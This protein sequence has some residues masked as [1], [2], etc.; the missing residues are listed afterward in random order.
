MCINDLMVPLGPSSRS[1]SL[2][3]CPLHEQPYGEAVS[4]RKGEAQSEG[5]VGRLQTQIEAHRINKHTRSRSRIT[6][7]IYALPFARP[8]CF[9][10]T[11]SH[12][13]PRRSYERWVVDRTRWVGFSTGC[14]PCS[15]PPGCCVWYSC[16]ILIHFDHHSSIIFCC[17]LKVH[18]I[19]FA[20]LFAVIFTFSFF[21]ESTQECR[22]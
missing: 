16:L 11:F 14:L 10:S 20:A 1:Q 6:T 4:Q 12:S 5:K 22:F 8:G 7:R 18:L 13:W 2:S 17:I 3:S 9:H 19:L 15:S 21:S